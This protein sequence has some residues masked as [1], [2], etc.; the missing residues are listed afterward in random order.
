MSKVFIEEDS[1]TAIGDAIRSKTGESSLLKVAEM[2]NKINS[3][4]GGSEADMS[5]VLGVDYNKLQYIC[6]DSVTRMPNMIPWAN[7]GSAQ[8]PLQPACGNGITN[9]SGAYQNGWMLRGVPVFGNNV[10]N[11]INAYGECTN[12]SPYNIIIPNSMRLLTNALY[13]VGA[14]YST[15]SVGEAVMD[16]TNVKNASSSFGAN[17]RCQNITIYGTPYNLGAYSQT[18]CNN[19]SYFVNGSTT[20]NIYCLNFDTYNAFRYNVALTTAEWGGGSAS[21]DSYSYVNI[22]ILT[23]NTITYKNYK[24]DFYTTGKNA[25]IFYV[26]PV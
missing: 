17:C 6:G 13:N 24:Y 19:L 1:L 25:R 10:Q 22:P 15:F 23:N 21:D 26:L 12:L 5:A 9:M 16:M 18:Q 7:N 20:H 8:L 4:S 3:I 14:N 11:A 2:P